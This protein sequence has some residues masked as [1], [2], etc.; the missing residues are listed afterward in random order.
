[1]K[2]SLF[3][4]LLIVI[5]PIATAEQLQPIENKVV[6]IVNAHNSQQSISQNGLGAIFKM[7]LRRWQ[8]GVPVTVF[9]INDKSPLHQKFCK[10]ILNVFPHQMRRVWDKAVFSGSGQAPIQLENAQAMLEKISSTPGAIGYL[11][12]S[13][14]T[15]NVKIIEVQ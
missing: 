11:N 13:H 8:D 2:N 12:A 7:R 1:M 4:I 5:I 9:V 14:L 6:T 3:F 15:D 10:K